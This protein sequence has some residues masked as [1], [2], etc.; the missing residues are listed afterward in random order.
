MPS[1]S[2]AIVSTTF[3]TA[4]RTPFPGSD[5]ESSS[6]NSQPR[7]CP[8]TRRRDER[9]SKRARLEPSLDLD[10]GVATRIEHL[11][12]VNVL[13]VGHRSGATL[14]DEA[15]ECADRLRRVDPNSTSAASAAS[16]SDRRLDTRRVDPVNRRIRGLLLRSRPS[17]PSTQAPPSWTPH[18]GYRRRSE[19][20]GRARRRRRRARRIWASRA[21][22]KHAS[23]RSDVR[24]R[25]P[26][27]RAWMYSSM[28]G[29]TAPAPRT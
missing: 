8:S 18:R 17:R 2:G 23:T 11:A 13:D 22:Q 15:S 4:R 21:P 14:E 1:I 19:T 16:I 27:L 3:W 24:I 10:G 12:R 5:P 29:P 20:R 9:T 6:R 25:A 28:S 26:V 7:A